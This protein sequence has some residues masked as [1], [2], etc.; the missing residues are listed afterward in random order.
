L[1]SHFP[2]CRQRPH[3]CAVSTS[4]GTLSRPFD[5]QRSVDRRRRQ[6]SDRTRT[7]LRRTAMESHCQRTERSRGKAMPRKVRISRDV[8]FRYDCSLLD[9]T[10]ISIQRSTRIRGRTTR[11]FSYSFC[12]NT[13]AINGPKSP[14][15]S[16]DDRT[17]RLRITGILR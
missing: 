8:V 4:L 15:T 14:G 12:I 3:G 16:M 7:R 11:I 2:L 10:I 6:E 1:V 17:T 9:G 13:S 5:H